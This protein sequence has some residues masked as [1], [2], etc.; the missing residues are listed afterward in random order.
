MKKRT[1]IYSREA[2]QVIGKTERSGRRLLNKIRIDLGKSDQQLVT[3]KEFADFTGIPE[4][5]IQS[6]IK[7]YRVY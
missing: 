7:E 5:E 4:D 2:A 6:R 3:I 1:C